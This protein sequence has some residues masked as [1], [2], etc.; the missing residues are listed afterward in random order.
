MN[1]K[2]KDNIK[3]AMKIVEASKTNID[4]I[5]IVAK[6][7]HDTEIL[8]D[9]DIMHKENNEYPT[10]IFLIEGDT[11]DG[12]FLG[13]KILKSVNKNERYPHRPLIV[14][15]ASYKHPGGGFL[16]G[17]S[18]Q[19]E[20]L[21]HHSL[22]FP[23]LNAFNDSWY[24]NHRKDS[25]G[26]LFRNEAL[27]TQ[28]VAFSRNIK[29][30]IEDEPFNDIFKSPAVNYADVLTIAAPKNKDNNTDE[31]RRANN[32]AF[33]ERIEFMFR[34]AADLAFYEDNDVFVT[35]P[36]GCGVSKQNPKLCA[37]IMRRLID[38][39]FKGSF[40]AIIFTIPD[41]NSENY[42]AFKEVFPDAEEILK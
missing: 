4:Y 36:I 12:L 41:K 35:G 8:S 25:N 21:C 10:K 20:F 18:T 2:M 6:M 42:K 40:R 32:L 7:I 34:C 29:N 17:A 28:N 24:H 22:L 13:E 16:R 15:Y 9:K 19:E 11:L 5:K 37:S 33:K 39:D 38:E 27:V 3:K 31:K 26:Y 1:T 30:I 23:V 14:N